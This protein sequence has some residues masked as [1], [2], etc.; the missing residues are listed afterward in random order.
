M[1]VRKS[2]EQACLWKPAGLQD[3]FKM[4]STNNT[5]ISTT[6][7]TKSLDLALQGGGSHGAFTWGVLERLLED[8][9]IALAGLC[10][11]SAGMQ[12]NGRQGAIDLLNAFWA[13]V[14]QQQ[15]YS[16]I[17]PS[18]WDKAEGNGSMDTS[19]AYHFFEMFTNMMSPYQYNPLNLNPLREIL[20][21][22]VDFDYLK[23]CKATQLFL[24]ATNV[25]TSRAKV[26]TLPEMSVDAVLASAC[27][28]F[29]F[30]AVEVDGE[31]YWD[32]GFMGNP[33]IFPLIDHTDTNDILI[34]QVNP[35]EIDK[36]PTSAI[37]IRDRIN[38][39]SFNASLM[40]EM[41]KVDFVQ[42]MLDEGVN[43]H[44]NKP[45]KKLYIHNINPEK[46]ISHYTVSSKLNAS[47]EFLLKL[48]WI[49]R[50]YADQWLE[51]NFQFIGKK[52]TCN[53]R[54]VFL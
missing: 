16:L 15:T 17:Q 39:L 7:M 49:G 27:I 50:Q 38:E 13:R 36:V 53:V 26:F 41:R 45:L 34:I 43:F 2:V 8:E 54:E 47:M 25:K 9:R 21:E 11:T 48:K 18:I 31:F 23:S 30:H 20:L 44:A 35:I 12:R 24:C 10:G 19:P 5:P 29:L 40:F 28:P 6:K 32:G 37:E 4:P 52:S 3:D 33:P 46:E 42:R 22:L 51:Q 1:Q 14:S